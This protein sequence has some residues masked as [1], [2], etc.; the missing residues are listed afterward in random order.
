MPLLH[1]LVCAAARRVPGRD[2][3]A[4]SGDTRDGR[5]NENARGTA[6]GLSA[7]HCRLEGVV[8]RERGTLQHAAGGRGGVTVPARGEEP[9]DREETTATPTGTDESGR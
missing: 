6:P 2:P 8:V 9:N 3:E 4:R 1:L 5:Q 7:A